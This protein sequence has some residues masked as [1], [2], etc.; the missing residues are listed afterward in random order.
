MEATFVEACVS[1]PSG[2]QS[3]NR[4]LCRCVFS[5]IR[6]QISFD[7][8]VEIEQEVGEGTDLSTTEIQPIIAECAIKHPASG[9]GEEAPS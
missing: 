2:G 3:N 9:P 6:E 4:L 7:R 8:F 5:G 1:G